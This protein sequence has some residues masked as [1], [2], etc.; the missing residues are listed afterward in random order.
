LDLRS[1]HAALP[2]EPATRRY[3]AKFER[4]LASARQV[5]AL[6]REGGDP[7]A[8]VCVGVIDGYLERLLWTFRALAY[9]QLMA[10]YISGSV[11]PGP[12]IDV[13][14]S[15]FP[16]FREV[17]QMAND[18]AQA[19]KHLDSLPDQSA[20]KNEMIKHMLRERTPPRQLQFAMSQRVYYE[21]LTDRI[22]FLAQNHPEACPL[23]DKQAD[24]RRYLVNW[25][26]YDSLENLPMLYLMAVEDSGDVPLPRDERRWPRVQS[27]LIAQSSSSLKLV[28]LATGF[29]RDFDDL[30]PKELHRVHVGPLYSDAYTKQEGSLR[31]VLAEAAGKPGFDWVLVWTIESLFSKQTVERP[32]GVFGVVN[33]EIFRLDHFAT[34]DRDTGASS[35]ERALILPQQPYQVLADRDPPGL[36]GVRKFVV[37]SEGQILTYA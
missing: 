5:N 22:V 29:D 16:V 9:K 18:L 20:L 37:G 28:T 30:H 24:R 26:V 15:G 32:V 19:R 1:D 23:D 13:R 27:H 36:R 3:F 6:A 34:K 35:I 17:L 31:D 25:A 12:E 2:N 4:V 14:D 10:K 11:V 8:G 21:I 33:R 7:F